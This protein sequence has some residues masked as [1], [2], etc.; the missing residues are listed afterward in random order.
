M[1]AIIIKQIIVEGY[2]MRDTKRAS[3][4]IESVLSKG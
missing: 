3:R 1:P 2:P 4:D